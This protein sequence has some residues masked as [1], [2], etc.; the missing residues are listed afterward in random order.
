MFTSCMSGSST[1]AYKK[2]PKLN[3]VLSP[4]FFEV[5]MSRLEVLGRHLV[6]QLALPSAALPEDLDLLE[7]W[8]DGLHETLKQEL[9]LLHFLFR[10]KGLGQREVVISEGEAIAMLHA[11]SGIRLK[12]RE[13]FLK[14]IDD[15][16]LEAGNIE[17]EGLDPDE[18]KNYA[19]YV[20]FAHLQEALVESLNLD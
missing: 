17:L 13:I 10:E 12:L 5:L 7:T 14:R 15:S 8:E 2:M 16:A 9:M 3:L 11:L 4:S 6:E 19:C 20:F 18:Q 1:R